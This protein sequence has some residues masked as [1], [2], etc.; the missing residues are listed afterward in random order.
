MRYSAAILITLLLA[1][2]AMSGEGWC[3]SAAKSKESRKTTLI[4]GFRSLGRA[5]KEPRKWKRG[6]RPQMLP[7]LLE[8]AR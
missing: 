4:Q 7:G 6:K 8:M 5:Q 1:V 2:P 3:G